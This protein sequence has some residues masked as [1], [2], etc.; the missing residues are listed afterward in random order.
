MD[1]GGPTVLLMPLILGKRGLCSFTKS[2][3]YCRV[4]ENM[5]LHDGD[6]FMSSDGLDGT[7]NLLFYSKA[8]YALIAEKQKLLAS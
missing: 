5:M 3:Q 7:G 1:I 2:T 6:F 4:T 8:L